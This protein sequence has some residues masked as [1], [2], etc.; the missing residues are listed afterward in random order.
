M[1]NELAR[2][3]HSL[4]LWEWLNVS[5]GNWVKFSLFFHDSRPL[6]HCSH[7]SLY[8]ICLAPRETWETTSII[9]I[10]RSQTTWS[11]TRTGGMLNWHGWWTFEN[12]PLRS[13]C[14]LQTDLSP[15]LDVLSSLRCRARIL[16]E[17]SLCYWSKLPTD[18][19]YLSIGNKFGKE[20]FT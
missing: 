10:A 9:H 1:P 4:S 12:V 11:R 17:C 2:C 19:P 20:H 18:L 6:V 7:S 3:D 5:D 14:D 16:L 15:W 13:W 8:L